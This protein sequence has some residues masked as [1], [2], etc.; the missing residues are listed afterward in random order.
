MPKLVVIGGMAAGM[1][2]GSKLRRERPEWAVRVLEAGPD[3]SFGACGLPYWMG[4]EVAGGENLV[5]L[6][7]E[8]T[9]RRGIDVRL[10]QRVRG[11]MEGK[12]RLEVED[13][14]SG[15]SYEE[16]YDA[17]L[18]ATGA[19]AT[20]PDLRGLDADNCFT[21]HDMGDG[22]RLA[23]FLAERRPRTAVIWGSGYIGLEMAEA[24]A[25]RGVAVTLINRSV[26]LMR[27]LVP[28]LRDRLLRELEDRGVRVL[29]GTQVLEAVRDGREIAHLRTDRGDLPTDLLL[30][31]TGVKPATEFLQGSGVPLAE[32][33]AIR[34]DETC[35]TGVHGIWAAGDCCEV[36]HMVTG[37]P[38]YLPLGTTANKMGRVAGANIGGARERFP[39]VVGTAIARV[40]GLEVGVA[41]LSPEDARQAGFDPVEAVTESGTRAG[42]Y[43]GGGS[44]LVHLTADRRGRVL[45]AQVAGSE[46]V[47]GRVDT[48]AAALTMGMKI[49]DLAMLDMAYAPPFAPVWD[50]LLVTAGVLKSKLG[51]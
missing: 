3:L 5:A 36:R 25:G 30:V 50:P 19:R 10:R 41:G 48:V 35:A 33:G 2:A 20:L 22:R 38:A 28:P 31:A 21:L 46:G 16:P 45:G 34:V 47:K 26:R 51:R 8:E 4:G 32:N 40:F 6:G 18:I 27:G 13:V 11:L 29:L 39:G 7:A 42:Y 37:R 43:P 17:L 44:T 1:S 24:L 9:A 12:K 14:A 49:E 23:P 15:R